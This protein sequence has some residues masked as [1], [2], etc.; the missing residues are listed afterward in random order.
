MGMLSIM[1]CLMVPSPVFAN[2]G[3]VFGPQDFEVTTGPP[4]PEV[5]N[6]SVQNLEGPFTLRIDNGG[7]ADTCKPVSS[8]GIVL[9]GVGVLA[10]KAL[11]PTV[12]VVTQAITLQ[13]DNE[14]IVLFKGAPGS[15]MTIQ[16][17]TAPVAEAGPDQTVGQGDMVILDGSG[18]SD[19]EGDPLTFHW[20]ITQEPPGSSATLSDPT[21]VLPTFFANAAGIYV[22]QLVVSD[23]TADSA[24]DTVT[25]STDNSLAVADAGPDQSVSAG[26]TVTLNGTGSSDVDG[27]LLT[28]AW[29]LASVPTG[30]VA[31][32]SDPTAILPTFVA[33]VEGTYVVELIVND[34]T[35]GSTP[36]TVAITTGNS[37]PVA[38]A[39]HD[40]TVLIGDTVQ[41]N[42]N[43]SNDVD[44]DALTFAWALISVPEGSAAVLSDPTAILPTFIAD[45]EGTYVA[46]LIVNDTNGCSTPDTVMITTDNSRPVA[47][48]GPD[49]TMVFVG[50]TVQLDGNGSSDVDGDLLMFA[51]S[52]TSVPTGS[53]AALSDP[54]V[55]L[56]TFVADMEGTYV[57]QLIVNDGMRNSEPDTVVI[58]EV[59][60][61]QPPTITSADNVSVAENTVF[62]I[63]V[64]STDDAD[65]EGAGLIYSLTG[66][67]DQSQFSINTDTGTLNFTSPPDF[68][69]PA[70]ADTNNVYEVDVTVTDSHLLTDVQ[71]ISVTVIDVVDGVTAELVGD[72]LFVLGT[73]SADTITVGRVVDEIVVNGGTVPISGGVP[74]VAN[75]VLIVVDGLEDDDSLTVDESG[76]AL[77]DAVLEGRA[78]NDTLVGGSGEDTLRGDI[79][80]DLLIGGDGV[81]TLRGGAGN[82]TLIGGRGNDVKLGEAGDD[83]FVWNNGD[84]SDLMEGGGDSDTVQVNGADAA[85][86]DFSI[87][88]NGARVRFQRNNLGL[89]ALDI[90][91]TENLDVNGQGGGDVIAGSVGL[92]GLIELDLDGGE[93]ND[94]LIGGD[95]VDTLRGGAGNDTLIGGRGNDVKL[96]EAGDDLFV[97]NNGDGSDLMEGGG[98]SDTVQVN[99][100]DAAGD[101]FSIAPNGARVRFQRNN[102]G[103]FALD[104]GTT[105]NLDVNGQGGGDV[106]AGSVGLLG[107]IELDLDGGEG[108]D[109]LIGGDG[110]DTLRGGAGNDTLIGGRGNDVKLGEAGDDLFVWNNGDGS[111]LMEGGGDSDTVQ[112]NGADAAGDDFSIAP[113]GA[114]VRFQ[115]N[116]LGLFALDIGTT[117]NLDV[118]GQGGGDVI[119]GS[120]GLLGLIE[121]DLD[122]GEGNDLLIGGDGVD[123]LRGGAGN[124]TLIGGRG[125][126]VKLGEAGDDLFVWN[127]GDG[128]DLM[129]G[130]GDSDT[131]QVNGADAAGDDFSIAPNGARVRF[132][133]NNLGLFA[134]DIGT[135]ENLDVNGQGGGDVIAGSVGLLG[136]IEL[137]L[138]GGEGNDLLIGGDGVDTLRGGAGNDTLIGGR[139]ND[140]KLGEAGDDLFVW[141]N[142]DGSD[143]MEGG[144]DSDTV[145]VNGADAAGDDFSIAPNGARVRFQRNNLGLFAL[146]IGTTENL[147]VNG[148]GGGDVIAGS[149]GLLGLI[150]LDLDGG[151]GNDLLIGGDGVDTLRG[152]AGNDTLIGGRGNDVK[153]GEA[154]DDLFVWNN[155]D[156]SDLMEGGGDSDTVQVNGADAAGD[157]FSIAPNGARVRFQRNN[158]GLFALDI[159]TTENLDVNGQGGGDV[160][161]G[162]VGLL[163]LIELDLDG[164]EGNDLLIGGDGNDLL[165]GNNGT[166][167]C[168]G[169]LGTD[170]ALGCETELNIP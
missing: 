157:D 170:T 14:L 119:A 99:G 11:N 29:S 100:A 146:D 82:D 30:S 78:G 73:P 20:A 148:Q 17:N 168:D 125:N 71:T 91:T 55:V 110:V 54:T 167:V 137:D 145:Q 28:F 136:L 33:D 158:L 44:N 124:D 9:N 46:Q 116:N 15:C 132:Q 3:F 108:N 112:V 130:G 12:E 61:N 38:D 18:S 53:A 141:N 85:G 127:N 43:G 122:G 76:G 75:T 69:N 7:L 22:I 151:E 139:G 36:D 96:G 37:S 65:A 159:G 81:D 118:N 120:V 152:G 83:L 42:G 164:G 64:E 131:V 23:G 35:G 59:K 92:L 26:D 163:G 149:V 90:G 40:Q 103:L 121:L 89:F 49:Q 95:G 106:I 154:G 57:A 13:A 63:D 58:L 8:V 86:D 87:A 150:E 113:N 98:D 67:S 97:W 162:S 31:A 109:L 128:S 107:L 32:L 56:P 161:A 52:L 140:V 166:D 48:A 16:I 156:G 41:L 93:G 138:D 111:D 117:E 153:L 70:D 84:G 10:P 79:G 101:D 165:N 27:D 51:W 169:G 147:D 144:G 126:D 5:I 24:P 88:P 47:D 21:A 134:L 39:G 34:G 104:I 50:D 129:E 135:T 133:R 102:L 4:E 60:E 114:R 115:R 66:G 68:E 155:G 2:S 1:L 77:P 143:L 19:A 62:V 45:V 72:T 160:I 94:L 123:T 142:G 25:I 6:F 74:T 105:E 80:N